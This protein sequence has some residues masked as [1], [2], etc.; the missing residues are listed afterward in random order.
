MSQTLVLSN[1][2][3]VSTGSGSGSSCRGASCSKVQR[4]KDEKNRN[5]DKEREARSVALEKAYVHDVYEQISGYFLFQR[6]NSLF[7]TF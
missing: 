7:F 5:T 3:L 2:S 6:K 1:S 4:E